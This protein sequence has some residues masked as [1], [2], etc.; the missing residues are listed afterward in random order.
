MKN[1]QLTLESMSQAVWYN[2]WT[3][4]KFNKFLKG[5]ILEVGCGIGNFTKTLTGYGQVF[6]IDINKEYISQTAKLINTGQVG[7]GDIETGVY[8]F[9]TQKFD[10]I[11]C[12][13]V[14]EHIKND[15]AALS[16]LFK[17]LKIGATLILLVPLHKLLYGEI[18]KSIGHFRRYEKD[19]LIKKMQSLGFKIIKVRKLNF[20]GSLGWFI[21][22]RVL[23]EKVL[24]DHKIK[25][26]N[27]IAPFILPLED[28]IEPPIGISILIIAQK[29]KR[30]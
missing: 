27:L 28:L 18:D 16:N 8:F 30:E 11:V 13:N 26:F 15:N 10:S 24:K 2:Q 3:L 20:L 7:F 12:I 25:I 22:G 1:D 29:D 5:K 23:K 14:L 4:R 6:A 17:L 21:A 19:D 9:D